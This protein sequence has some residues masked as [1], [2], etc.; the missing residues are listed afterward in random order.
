MSKFFKLNKKDFIKSLYMTILSSL[1]S[2]AYTIT[3]QGTIPNLSQLK[4]IGLIAL[5][6]GV[7]YIVKNLFTN[8]DG[9][10]FS[11]EPK[12]AKNSFQGN[13]T[14]SVEPDTCL[15]STTATN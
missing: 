8:S 11:K 7:A 10:T 1:L 5:S 3:A 2:G 9:T 6:A 14:I 4:S 12:I 15:P 13:S